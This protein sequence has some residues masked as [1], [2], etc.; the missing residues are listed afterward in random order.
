[1]N[2]SEPNKPKWGMMAAVGAGVAASACCTIPLLLVSLGAGGAWI[3]SF[4]ALE[5]FRP[6]FI[7][8]ALGFLAVAGYREYR[9]ATGPECDC[10]VTMQDK[11][12]RTLLVL[13]VVVTLGLI[14]SPWVIKGASDASASELFIPTAAMQEVVLD[15]EGMTCETCP[16]TV[17]KALTRLEG[18]EAVQVTYEPPRAVVRYVPDK[19]TVEDIIQATVNVGYP[20]EQVKPETP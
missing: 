6:A 17:H 1:M 14:V 11:L 19:V 20:G 8:V 2:P 9:T 4:T 3:S 13:G 16:I 18:V 7:A 15:I 5:P 10:E 12:R